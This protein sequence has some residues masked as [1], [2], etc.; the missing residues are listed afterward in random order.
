M[1]EEAAESGPEQ[2]APNSSPAATSL[3]LAG[4]SREEADAFL[5][6]QRRLTALQAREL[7]HELAL[8]HWSLWVRHLSGLLKLTFEIGLA[9]VAVGLAWFI[10][11][12][13][14]NAAHA[15]GLV[16]EPFSVPPDLAAR[17]ITG[18]VVASQM[19]DQLTIM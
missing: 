16:I 8:R 12:A 17:G 11:A 10:G 6:D 19:L 9:V 7:S 15:E 13:V 2:P 1:S 4:A 3:A 14:W 18:Q 5:R